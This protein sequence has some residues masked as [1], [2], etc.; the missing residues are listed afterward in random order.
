[1]IGEN[2]QID[3]VVHIEVGVVHRELQIGMDILKGDVPDVGAWVSEMFLHVVGERK[4]RQ[5]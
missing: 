1:M 5:R 4:M 3:I 2:H